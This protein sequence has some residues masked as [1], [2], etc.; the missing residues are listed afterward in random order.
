LLSGYDDALS[1]ISLEL[2]CFGGLIDSFPKQQGF[3]ASC[4]NLLARILDLVQEKEHHVSAG[5]L[6]S[7]DSQ[8]QGYMTSHSKR[9]IIL[10]ARALGLRQQHFNQNL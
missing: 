8:V 7:S 10:T 4:N 1:L 2:Y 3:L 9:A 5:L 6:E